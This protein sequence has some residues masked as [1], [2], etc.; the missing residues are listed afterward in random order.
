MGFPAM[1]ENQSLSTEPV[2]S[3]ARG[4][5][6]SAQISDLAFIVRRI[7][8]RA[9][10]DDEVLFLAS[11]LNEALHTTSNVSKKDVIELMQKRG[12]SRQ[13]A[14]QLSAAIFK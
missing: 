12:R 8:K 6:E 9:V 5:I 14:E 1:M 13:K 11:I 4:R 7:A 2:G 10:P 3:D